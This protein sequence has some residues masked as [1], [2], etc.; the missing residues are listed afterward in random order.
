MAGWQ[1]PGA[2][3]WT[4]GGM[5]GVG[6]IHIVGDGGG[7]VISWITVTPLFIFVRTL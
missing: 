6:V 3:G 2:W 7:G 4:Q 1:R 5:V